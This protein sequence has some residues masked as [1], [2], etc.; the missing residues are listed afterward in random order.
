MSTSTTCGRESNRGCFHGS[1]ILS[2]CICTTC[3]KPGGK[4]KPQQ[5][6]HHQHHPTELPVFIFFL[7]PA[8][9]GRNL[10]QGVVTTQNWHSLLHSLL[11]F[12]LHFLLHSLLHFFWNIFC[13]LFCIFFCFC[14]QLYLNFIR[15]FSMQLQFSSDG[16]GLDKQ[17]SLSDDGHGEK[18]IY[19]VYYPPK[20]LTLTDQ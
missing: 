11:H 13:I 9:G 1:P 19:A 12:L 6:S 14:K 4:K 15:V 20:I 10:L 3:K 17:H 7:S 5:N 16:I 8:G 2:S 18:Q